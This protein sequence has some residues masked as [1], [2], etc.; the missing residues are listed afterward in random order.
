MGRKEC[1]IA[2]VS[3]G[4]ALYILEVSASPASRGSQVLTVW[5][6]LP[7][8]GGGHFTVC[9]C[10]LLLCLGGHCTVWGYMLLLLLLRPGVGGGALYS[11]FQSI[12]LKWFI[13]S[14]AGNHL[15]LNLEAPLCYYKV[16]L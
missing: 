5:T 7:C 1:E 9:R 15:K 12:L 10:A 2:N 16:I 14:L 8:A 11:H 6:C 13:C 4:S 3:R